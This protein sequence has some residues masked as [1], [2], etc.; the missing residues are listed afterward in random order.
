MVCPS[1]QGQQTVPAAQGS[2][3][4]PCP[5]LDVDPVS[6]R[7]AC[8]LPDGSYD[9]SP[10]ESPSQPS[11]CEDWTLEQVVD[12]Y[13]FRIQ[14]FLNGCRVPSTTNAVDHVWV[15]EHCDAQGQAVV[16]TLIVEPNGTRGPGQ[17]AVAVRFPT[18]RRP[19]PDE[20]RPTGYVVSRSGLSGAMGGIDH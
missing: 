6:R 10:Y 7:F 11:A 13:E 15:A 4:E 1:C 3:V 16:Q 17:F 18:L 20:R 19:F 14:E 9:L 12:K 8:R 5:A 2:V